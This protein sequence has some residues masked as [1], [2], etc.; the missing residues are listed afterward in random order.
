MSHNQKLFGDHIGKNKDFP[1]LNRVS[2]ETFCPYFCVFSPLQ[3]FSTKT[4]KL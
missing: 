2:V 3:K 1:V 4:K